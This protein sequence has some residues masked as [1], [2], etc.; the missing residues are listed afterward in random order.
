MMLPADAQRFLGHHYRQDAADIFTGDLDAV[1]RGSHGR[2]GR[3]S[4]C[5]A[6][7]PDGVGWTQPDEP[8]EYGYTLAD[9]PHRARWTAIL[10]HLAA[11]PSHLRDRLHDAQA[12]CI[13]EERRHWDAM[14]AI[15]VGW[16]SGANDDER[17][18][19]DA[20]EEQHWAAS[21]RLYAA[22][23]AA[24]LALLPLADDEP[25]DLIEW[26]AALA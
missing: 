14:N 3:D 17:A 9:W 1:K 21:D 22:R 10:A 8:N 13:A 12:T 18:Q 6:T 19:L 11:Q 26:A 15:H 4:W 5:F 20:E 24:L 25:A 23:D 2:W 7:C 16:Y